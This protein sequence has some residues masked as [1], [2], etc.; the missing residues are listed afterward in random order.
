MRRIILAC[1]LAGVLGVP[2]K[3][4]E[5]LKFRVV[6]YPASVQSQQVGDVNGHVQ[7]V[8]RFVGLASFPD[9]STAR[10]TV[11]NTGDAIAVPGGGGTTNGYENIVFSDGSELWWKYTGTY[12]LDSKGAVSGSGTFIV[13]SGK[14]RYEGAKGD[15]TF[16][17]T[18]NQ[19]STA[20]GETIGAVDT[21]LNIKK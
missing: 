1:A 5:T 11:F 13:T 20:G 6:Q 10:T 3:A 16:E 2:A 12:K 8:I 7:S 4:D 17:V 21:V 18:Q 15:G 19:T 9:G 14:G